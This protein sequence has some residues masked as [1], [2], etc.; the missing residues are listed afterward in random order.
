MLTRR[1]LARRRL[2]QSA[3]GALLYL[4][5][6]KLLD[7]SEARAATEITKRVLF[8]Y[9]PSGVYMHRYR[10]AGGDRSGPIGELNYITK[11]LE[12]H[13]SDLIMFSGLCFRGGQD[14]NGS[15]VQVLAGN[16]SKGVAATTQN[17][18]SNIYSLDQRIADRIGKDSNKQSINLSINNPDGRLPF[19]EPLS[20]KNGSKPNN[21]SYDPK[22]SFIDMFGNFTVPGGTTTQKEAET[23]VLYGK[24]SILDFLKG[25]LQRISNNLSG[26]DKIAFQTHVDAL[27]EIDRDINKAIGNITPTTMTPTGPVI[28]N[29]CSPKPTIDPMF[30]AN[31]RENQGYPWY[32]ASENIPAVFRLERE[33]I[34]QAFACNLTRVAVWQIGA[35]HTDGRLPTEGVSDGNSSHHDLAHADTDVYAALNRGHIQEIAKL[36][37]D[38]KATP[39]GDHSLFDETLTFGGSCIG[40]NANGH[41]KDNIPCFL[42]GNAFGQLNTGRVIAYPYSNNGGDG[43]GKTYNHLLVSIAH[44]MGLTDINTVGNSAAKGPLAEL[45]AK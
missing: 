20:W 2:L 23:N 4:P 22:A 30:P 26:G 24:K 37:A 19:K 44:L 11:P 40:E 33:L 45:M 16:G 5:L 15:M 39:M 8:T 12:P 18:E 28:S 27:G 9:F 31:Q 36:V 6:L 14:H 13:K 10:P 42:I 21:P 29:K 34:R 7:E 41:G 25:D 32:C 35:S 43:Q 17:Q 1:G 38:L 3:S